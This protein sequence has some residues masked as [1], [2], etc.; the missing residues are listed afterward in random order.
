MILGCYTTAVAQGLLTAEQAV[1][2]ALKNNYDIL[3]ANNNAIIADKNNS[4]GNAGMLPNISINAGDNF[5]LNNINQQFTDGREVVQNSVQSNSANASVVLNWT[6]FDGL[7]MFAT[8]KR[9]AIIEQVGA[10]NFKQQMQNTVGD[11]LTT[12]YELVRQKQQINFTNELIKI[13]EERVT[14]ADRKFNVGSTGKSEL[15]QAKVDLN[16]T[17][18]LQLNQQNAL[19]QSKALLNQLLAREVT[20]DFDVTDSIPLGNI[21]A[22]GELTGA[23]GTGN[24]D[25]QVGQKSI[26]I[27]QQIKR[28]A[29]AQRWPLININAGYNF[30]NTQNQA[31]FQLFNRNYGL[32]LGVSASIPIFNGFNINRQVKV[33]QI[34]VNS[35]QLDLENIRLKINQRLVSAYGNWSFGQQLLALEEDNIKLAKQN[36]DIVVERFKLAQ[37]TS[38][39]LRDAQQ[40]YQDAL[41]RLTAARYNAKTAEIELQ[42]LI[43]TLVR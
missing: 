7:R 35:R 18:A 12:Y 22:L 8:K 38:L 15:L 3:I 34:E 37:S 13:S 16:A 1:E 23:A 9:L 2:I 39:E 26:L 28:E 41:Y 42:K 10:I 19:Q 30:V 33:S 11:V 24:F 31:G 14:I 21:P 6:I 43:G 25:I 29:A 4:P 40:S 20:T 32:G 36:V 17:K 27:A 5:S